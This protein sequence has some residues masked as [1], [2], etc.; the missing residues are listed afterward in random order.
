M[1]RTTTATTVRLSAPPLLAGCGDDDT[2]SPPAAGG[3][4]GTVEITFSD[5]SVPPNGDRVDVE[6]HDP[7]V[8]VVQLEVS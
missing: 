5:G 1:R 4:T 6:S 2:G 3:D 7:K 8:V